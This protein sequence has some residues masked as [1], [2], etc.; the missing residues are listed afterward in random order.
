M[1]PQVERTRTAVLS[2]ASDLL[3]RYGPDAVTHQRVAEESRVGRATIYRHWPERED[4]LIDVLMS[5]EPYFSDTSQTGIPFD[6]IRKQ[7]LTF[8]DSLWGDL[9][10]VFAAL[11]GRAEWDKNVRAARQKVAQNRT[12]SLIQSI[13]AGIDRGDF[14]SGLNPRLASDQL[15][16]VMVMRRFVRE[17][18]MTNPELEELL[19]SVLKR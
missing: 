10:I 1:D 2:A 5:L 6:A 16:G 17:D 14:S 11:I 18:K 19:R 13:Q 9:G 15:I 7:M 8:R 12:A 3:Y 4:L